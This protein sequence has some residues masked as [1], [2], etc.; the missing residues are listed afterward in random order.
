MPVNSAP[1]PHL[2]E[3]PHVFPGPRDWQDYQNQTAV[4][5]G[6]QTPPDSHDERWR[7]TRAQ[8]FLPPVSTEEASEPRR[9]TA[10]DR[11]FFS[12]ETLVMTPGSLD[13]PRKRQACGRRHGLSLWTL[14]EAWAQH[15]ELLQPVLSRS[16]VRDHYFVR[17]NTAHLGEGYCIYIPRERPPDRPLELLWQDANPVTV[18]RLILVLESG[19]RL[20]LVESETGLRS[21]LR[22]VVREI[23][24][25]P[26]AKLRHTLLDSLGEHEI[27]LWTTGVCIHERAAYHA[28]AVHAGNHRARHE[29]RIALQGAEARATLNFASLLVPRYVFDLQTEILHRADATE[30]RQIV[31]A[32]AAGHARAVYGGTVVVEAGTHEALAH[33]QSRGLLLERGA[34]VDTRPELRIHSDD[35]RCTHGA[36]IGELDPDILF[37]LQS[38]GVDPA[39]A[40]ALLLQAFASQA[41]DESN[42]RTGDAPLSPPITAQLLTLVRRLVPRMPE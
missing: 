28:R 3:K 9:R 22:N 30:S 14:E 18:R 27:W 21:G 29:L 10:L 35:V 11:A 37:Y 33:Q 32:A 23:D 25:H 34:E 17:W 1:A 12:D 31:H 42:T 8:D 26:Q 20:D 6:D 36:S 24:L 2:P 4:V 41:L 16:P 38:R 40:R 19:A 7:Y 39:R 5:L 15:P 13:T